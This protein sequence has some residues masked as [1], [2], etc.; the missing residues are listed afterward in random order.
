LGYGPEFTSTIAS[1]FT[2]IGRTKCLS[3]DASRI[4]HHTEVADLVRQGVLDHFSWNFPYTGIEEDDAVHE[5][6]I[7]G[8][9]LSVAEM[10]SSTEGPVSK[11]H[12]ALT[13][14]G[15]QFSRWMVMRSAMRSGWRLVQWDNFDWTEYPGY[16]PRRAN[17]E[18]FP[19]SDS[20]FYVFS[21]SKT[22]KYGLPITEY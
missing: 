19:E 5:S 11:V 16:H 6:L 14:Q 22:D 2:E 9:F 1:G 17:G 4:H 12:L 13:L 15:D 18:T 3:V 21:K 10:L 7:L 8:T 20:R